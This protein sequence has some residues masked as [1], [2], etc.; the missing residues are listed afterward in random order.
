MWDWDEQKR[1]TNL[2]IHGVDFAQAGLFDWTTAVREPDLRRDYGEER[3][4]ATGMIGLRL[5]VMVF[6][7]RAGQIRIISLRKANSREQAR[8][9]RLKS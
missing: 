3:I 6:T 2:A 4:E 5:H 9:E 8:W 1:M 7:P